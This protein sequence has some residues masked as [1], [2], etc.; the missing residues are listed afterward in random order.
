MGWKL[1]KHYYAYIMSNKSRTLYVGVTDD[2]ENRVT[3]H[4]RGTFHGFTTKYHVTWLVWYEVFTDIREAIA[5]EK[6]IKGWTR[7]KKIEL[8]EKMNPL[9]VDLAVCTA[10]PAEQKRPRNVILSEAKDLAISERPDPSLR[11]G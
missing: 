9:W 7:A 10:E 1:M 2:L 4:K 6:R 3:Q 8:I 5:A 11:S